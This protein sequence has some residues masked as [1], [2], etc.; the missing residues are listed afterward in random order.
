MDDIKKIVVLIDAD[1]T[2][3]KMLG[4]VLQEISKYGQIVVKRAYGNW[5]KEC[6]KNWGSEIKRLAIK[7]EQ[8]FD[9]VSG[10]NTTDIALVIDAMELLYSEKYDGFAIVSSDSDYTPLAI[11]L[12]ESGVRVIGVGERKTPEA[13]RNSCDKFLLLENLLPNNDETIDNLIDPDESNVSQAA[14]IENEKV[15]TGTREVG[16]NIDSKK[17]EEILHELLKIAWETYQDAEEYVN[18]SAAG[19]YV[20]RVKPDFDI[21]T[22]GFKKLTEFIKASNNIYKYRTYQGKG[23]A[24]IFAYKCK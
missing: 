5:Q 4:L 9:Y 3:C 13:F 11:K 15:K 17:D 6:L 1:N 14:V 21:R 12:R 20:K 8:Q 7:A 18:V 23:G 16:D 2:Q 24:K 22:Y 19:N 10:K